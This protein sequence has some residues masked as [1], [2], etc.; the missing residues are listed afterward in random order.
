[1]VL[2]R[3]SALSAFDVEVNN[4]CLLAG[5][6][7][8]LAGGLFDSPVI[9]IDATVLATS[10]SSIKG[11]DVDDFSEMALYFSFR[12]KELRQQTPY[13]LIPHRS[14]RASYY[15]RAL[16]QKDHAIPVLRPRLL[17][18]CLDA[19]LERRQKPN[20]VKRPSSYQS[21]RTRQ[22]RTNCK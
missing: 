21:R 20:S 1:M 14:L 19:I 9:A 7:I 5:G 11:H 3:D 18:A 8:T 10:F 15:T 22:R 2:Q 16:A 13:M 4:N 12:S 6:A 17:Q